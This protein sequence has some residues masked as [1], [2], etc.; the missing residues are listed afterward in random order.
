MKKFVLLILFFSIS[1]VFAASADPVS[2][3][4]P[5]SLVVTGYNGARTFVLGSD[6]PSTDAKAEANPARVYVPIKSAVVDQEKY[7][8]LYFTEGITS[9]FSI[10]F[11]APSYLQTISFPLTVISTTGN[12]YLYAALKLN[13]GTYGAIAKY[14]ITPFPSGTNNSTVNFP[15]SPQSI[16]DQYQSGTTSTCAGLISTATTDVPSDQKFTVYFFQSTQNI[17]VPNGPVVPA[18]TDAG[19]VYFEVQMSNRIYTTSEIVVSQ[20]PVEVG[21]GRVNLNIS[22]SNSMLD[23]TKILIYDHK[24][25]PTAGANL[26][27]GAY[28]RGAFIDLNITDPNAKKIT[29]NQQSDGSPLVNGHDYYFSVM[30]VD[31]FKFGTTISDYVI[32]HPLEIQQ[33][34]KKQACFLLTAGF[35]EEHYIITYFR[36]F[37]DKV[38]ENYSLGRMF[39]GF[40]Y[41][42]APKYALIIYKSPLLRSVIRGMAYVLYFIFSYIKLLSITFITIIGFI[43]F[44]RA[45]KWQQ[46]KRILPF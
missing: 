29:V 17:A 37:R 1:Q 41:E 11:T 34:L 30:L 40:Y 9:L 18:S 43:I 12:N 19:G 2:V 26:P 36:N 8:S 4:N 13:D 14:S 38:L 21:D 5:K 42:T 10:N 46:Q 44:K 16:C 3:Y 6:N 35:G 31:K 33:L 28:T 20:G 7:F 25:S 27:A 45:K 22:T 23:F 24:G 32:A 15:V 39:I